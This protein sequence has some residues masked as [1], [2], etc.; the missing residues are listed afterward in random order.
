VRALPQWA[1][2]ELS[3]RHYSYTPDNPQ[4]LLW[5]PVSNTLPVKKAA[6]I[7]GVGHPYKIPTGSSHAQCA[8]MPAM[9]PEYNPPLRLHICTP[10][11]LCS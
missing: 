1:L 10:S 11:H 8:R 3:V 6:G 5:K 2:K 4:C 7:A 9:C